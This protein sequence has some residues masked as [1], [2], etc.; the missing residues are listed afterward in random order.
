MNLFSICCFLSCSGRPPGLYCIPLSLTPASQHRLTRD[1]LGHSFFR[2]IGATRE[3]L[4]AAHSA[5]R[6]FCLFAPLFLCLS[7]AFHK[8]I[9][10]QDRLETTIA[11]SVDQLHPR[12]CPSSC[13]FPFF[14]V[15]RCRHRIVSKKSWPRAPKQRPID[16]GGG[17]LA[18]KTDHSWGYFQRLS[19]IKA[20]ESSRL[21]ERAMG[22]EPTSVPR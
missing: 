5:H 19:R 9:P 12:F 2:P 11:N 10:R 7:S 13:A 17:H 3:A 8:E 16:G 22:I 6:T 20:I 1:P 15:D 14:K 18:S 4:I 21:M